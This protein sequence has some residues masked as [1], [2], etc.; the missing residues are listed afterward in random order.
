MTSTGYL[1]QAGP[2]GSVIGLVAGMLLMLVIA[3]ADAAMYERKQELKAMGART[4]D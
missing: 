3:R 4:R 2:A 1:S